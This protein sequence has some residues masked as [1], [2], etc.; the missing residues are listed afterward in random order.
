MNVMLHDPN[1]AKRHHEKQVP[2]DL[3]RKVPIGALI[4]DMTAISRNTFRDALV[5]HMA[6]TGVSIGELSAGTG[7]T[8]DTIKKLRSRPDASTVIVNAVLISSY[9]GLSIERFMQMDDGAEESTL[10]ELS[11]LLFP[12]ERRMVEAQVRGLLRERGSK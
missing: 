2:I 7:V 12:D 6:R 3:L 5:W 11:E 9:F 8:P 10:H 1:S 4:R